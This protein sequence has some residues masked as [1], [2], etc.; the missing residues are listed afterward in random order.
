MIQEQTAKLDAQMSMLAKC[1][2]LE[3]IDKKAAA[4]FENYVENINNNVHLPQPTL[5]PCED[6]FQYR[7]YGEC[8]EKQISIVFGGKY[9]D[10]VGGEAYEGDELEDFELQNKNM[11]SKKIFTFYHFYLNLF[12]SVFFYLP[13]QIKKTWTIYQDK[14]PK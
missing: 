13:D 6:L 4:I 11:I 9:D 7:R 3:M 2:S 14:I 8:H 10:W 1:Q 12:I 5:I